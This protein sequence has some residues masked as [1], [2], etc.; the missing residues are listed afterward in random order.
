MCSSLFAKSLL[1][2]PFFDEKFL[3]CKNIIYFIGV[4]VLTTGLNKGVSKLVGR[5]L[6]NRAL[7]NEQVL[8][9]VVIGLTSWGTVT[10]RTRHVIKNQV[11]DVFVCTMSVSQHI[12]ASYYWIFI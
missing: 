1:V 12:F 11:K 5:S 3:I 6:Y 8:K 10:E 4:W 9:P 7:L 2:L